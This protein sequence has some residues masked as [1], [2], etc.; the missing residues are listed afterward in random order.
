MVSKTLFWGKILLKLNVPRFPKRNLG[1]FYSPISITYHT[2]KEKEAFSETF[3]VTWSAVDGMVEME[4]NNE[5]H[6]MRSELQESDS[7]HLNSG[8]A[9]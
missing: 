1:E 3:F 5:M 2:L 4:L 7:L 9:T 8:S 6:L